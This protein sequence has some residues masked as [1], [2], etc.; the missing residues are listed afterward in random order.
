[1]ETATYAILYIAGILTGLMV[2][3][4]LLILIPTKEA[5]NIMLKKMNKA[6]K[7]SVITYLTPE[8]ERQEK[9]DNKIRALFV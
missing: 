8:E 1:M 6:E 3:V 9:E 5:R 7:A 4:L 2:S